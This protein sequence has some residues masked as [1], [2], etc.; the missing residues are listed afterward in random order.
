M[1][2][3]KKATKSKAQASNRPT[4]GLSEAAGPMKDPDKLLLVEKLLREVAIELQTQRPKPSIAD[5]IRLLELQKEL[6]RER[7]RS[8]EVT[9]VDRKDPERDPGTEENT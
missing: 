9:W 2:I 1:A 3:A 8:I 5:F 7:P 6:A 4:G